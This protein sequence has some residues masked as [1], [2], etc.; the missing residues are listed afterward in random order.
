M[1]RD[2][3]LVVGLLKVAIE[4]MRCLQN[5][6]AETFRTDLGRIIRF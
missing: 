3:E 2:T 6:K 5:R 4:A 1:A